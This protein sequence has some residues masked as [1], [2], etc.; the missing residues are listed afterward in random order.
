M[1][2]VGA[3]VVLNWVGISQSAVPVVGLP[4][5]IIAATLGVR[6]QDPS[7]GLDIEE[8]ERVVHHQEMGLARAQQIA[9]VK[10]VLPEG[11]LASSSNLRR[12]VLS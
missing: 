8:E 11:P 12:G 1:L 10:A 4:L 6:R 7:A 2:A 5:I 9:A 3:A